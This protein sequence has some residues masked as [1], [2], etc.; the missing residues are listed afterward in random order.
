[1][2]V[3]LEI[4][5]SKTTVDLSFDNRTRLRIRKKKARFPEF[6]TSSLES[7]KNQTYPF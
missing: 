5:L 4:R 3:L 1:M 6:A 7:S 2:P